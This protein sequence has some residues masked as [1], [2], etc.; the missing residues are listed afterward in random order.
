[1]RVLAVSSPHIYTTRDVW[2]KAVVGLR[3]AGV[4]V[5]TFDLI[6]RLQMYTFLEET[7]KKSK[8]F[9]LPPAYATHTM[10]YEA[11]TGA[12]LHHNV[13]W[14]LVVSPQY[15]PQQIASLIRKA[16]I[17]T[18]CYMTECPYEDTIDTPIK[19]S[20]FD[21]VLVNDRNSKMLYESFAPR[22]E[23]IPHSFDPEIHYP[24][25]KERRQRNVIFIGTGYQTRGQ[26]LQQ[27]DWTKIGGRL[28]LYGLWERGWLGS[29]SSLRPYVRGEWMTNNKT[30]EVYR[31]SAAAFSIHRLSRYVGTTEQIIEGEAY[32]MGPRNYELAACRTFQVS[33]Y[34]EEVVDVFG[35]SMPIY[36]TP[37]ELAALMKRAFREPTW[38]KDM[39]YR[40]WEAVQGHTCEAQM[41]KVAEILAA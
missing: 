7:A 6:P 17:K 36:N 12:A 4:E 37:Q 15:F 3:R 24:P 31:K 35:D 28:D 13:D 33:D 26:F 25:E 30:A 38:R 23:Y 10:A 11:I 8:K 18:A 34:R 20:H 19:A 40:Q 21:L 27:I 2:T 5:E 39:A 29:R 14:V 41:A 9:G 1:M 32:S 22:V 16:G